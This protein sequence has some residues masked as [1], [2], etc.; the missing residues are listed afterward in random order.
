M[1]KDILSQREDEFFSSLVIK[2]NQK[3]EK[4]RKE[5]DYIR[6][7]TKEL[8]YR[9]CRDKLMLNDDTISCV[10]ISIN[11]DIDK[12]I[13]AYKI[14]AKSF[15]HYLRQVCIYRIRRVREDNRFPEY[16]EIEYMRESEDSLYTLDDHSV[17]YNGEEIGSSNMLFFNPRHY[18]DM[19]IKSLT[20]FITS[21]QNRKDYTPRSRSEWVLR[22]KLDNKYFRRNFLFFIL[23][24][25]ANGGDDEAVN[26]ARVFQT[27]EAA[28]TR[29]LFLKNEIIE[30]NYPE[31]EKNL[32]LAAMHWR[33]MA[34]LKNSMYKARSEDE[35]RILK[36]NY[37]TQVRCHRN[38]IKDAQR[39]MRGIIHSDI[40][41]TLGVCRTTVTMGIRKV[42]E[43]LERINGTY[44]V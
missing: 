29:L 1:K 2:Y 22:G 14:S 4:D 20:E 11:D 21:N 42:K 39:S 12:I 3:Q 26:Y 36:D 25:P 9:I 40:A 16:L 28:F 13:N 17:V 24:L 38:R 43:E 30:R 31:R 18:L 7:R 10:Y 8:V 34:K 35:Y 15:N 23:S 32:C 27:D 41:D 5:E 6:E 19:D 37:M 33:M 44:S